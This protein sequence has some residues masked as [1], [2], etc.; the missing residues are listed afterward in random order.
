MLFASTLGMLKG[1]NKPFDVLY[2]R[3]S[4]SHI[5]L[6]YD[7]LQEDTDKI[8]GWFLEQPEVK[9]VLDYVPYFTVQEPMIHHGKELDLMVNL[10]EH[11]DKNLEQD[12]IM[13]LHGEKKTHPGMGE[14]WIPDHLA[15][16][17][18]IQIGDTLG[19]PVSSGLYP[20]IVSATVVDAQ[21]AS[22]LFNPT[23]A[24]V[25]PGSLTF[26]LPVGQLTRL[27]MGVRLN[28]PHDIP[29]LWARFNQA[30]LYNGQMLEYS[31]FKSV[32]LSFYNIISAVL[33]VF[34]VMAILA[35]IFIL[36][37][38]LSG[39]IAS[40]YRLIGIYKAQGFSPGNVVTIYVLQYLVLAVVSLPIG[41]LGSLLVTNAILSSLVKSIGLV[42]LNFSFFGPVAIT[43]GL[44]LVLVALIS[45]VGS[46]KAGRIKP[47]EAIRSDPATGSY[48]GGSFSWLLNHLI[49][50][51]PVFLG[52]RTLLANKQ[53]VLY[54]GFSL[55]LAIFILVFSINIS[56]SFARLKDNKAAWGFEDSDIQVRL[57]Q[58]IA[59]PLEHETFMELIKNEKSVA[60]VVPYSYCSA[61]IPAS[62]DKAMQE[63]NGKVYNGDMS[64]IGL[65]NQTGRHPENADEMALCLL[66]AEELGI[67]PGDSL[68]VFL[69]GQSITYHITGI[70]QDISNMGRGFRLPG[71]AMKELNP[72]FK[73]EFYAI[74]LH[75]GSSVENFKQHLQEVYAET[76]LIELSIEERKAVR[77]TIAGMRSS[78]LLVSLFFLS[79]LFAV[80]FNDALMNIH[81][82]RLGFGIFKTIGMT[83][84]QI[85]MSLVYRMAVLTIAC[86]AVG[87]PMALLLSPPLISGITSGIG[88]AEFPYL[89]EVSGTILVIPAMLLFTGLSVWWASGRVLEIS[90]KDLVTN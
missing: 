22:G 63:V 28:S 31:L 32:F 70:Y 67:E 65:V 47:V 36:Y 10:T 25:A 8:A 44:F 48:S 17:H 45:F 42:N 4:A 89:V 53:R 5:L 9:S 18:G 30:H 56:H 20:L 64:D 81:E 2:E 34:S 21:Y 86:L 26:Y 51:V 7:H 57:N 15:T 80:L 62:Q 88:L 24:W 12:Q 72:L 84:V 14:I 43:T 29:S 37:T 69:E 1:I 58:K 78:L 23:R 85:R 82:F 55:L 90:P 40:D 6:F 39:T 83:P 3:L 35:A 87:V 61:T 54:T 71:S 33:M 16:N 11:L 13:I 27:M 41:I 75:E 77:S 68:E 73:P 52:L 60:T 49:H 19:M 59:L 66:T 79:I 50:N 76:V 74:R 46:R 38:M